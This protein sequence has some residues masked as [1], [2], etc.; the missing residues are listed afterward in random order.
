M[1]LSLL[2]PPLAFGLYLLVA[3]LLNWVG[4]ALAGPAHPG[5]LKDSTYASGEAAP[6][7]LAA[8]GYGPYFVTAL[9]FGV[10]HLGVLVVATSGLTPAA[11]LFLLGLLAA[12]LVL[13]LG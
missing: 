12:L 1:S 10:L 8:L 2:V 3:G 13:I 7:G 9:F 6:A 4:R 5:A 11:G